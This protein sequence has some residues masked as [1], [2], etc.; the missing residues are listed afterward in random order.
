MSAHEPSPTLLPD[1]LLPTPQSLTLRKFPHL[2]SLDM[3]LLNC[4]FAPVTDER[5][6]GF[7]RDGVLNQPSF[8]CFPFVEDPN[9][10]FGM[11]FLHDSE[12]LYAFGCLLPDDDGLRDR[13]KERAGLEIAGVFTRIKVPQ[14]LRRYGYGSRMCQL[15]DQMI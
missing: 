7:T 10:V 6:F 3:Q 9:S 1:P 14:R 13:L 5:V 11:Y 4:L 8:Q 12:R 2:G 15:F